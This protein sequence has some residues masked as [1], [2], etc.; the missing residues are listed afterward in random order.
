[1]QKNRD[2]STSLQSKL[3]TLRMDYNQVRG[4]PFA[5]F[6]CPI[7]FRDEDVPLCK[8][9]IVNQAFP[10]S[11]SNWTVQRKDVDNFYGSVFEADFLAFRYSKNRS[12]ENALTDRMLQKQLNP[13][14]LLDDKQLDYFFSGGDIPEH[15]TRLNIEHEG[16]VVQF[17]LK[18][19]PESVL[20][21]T[22]QKWE[23]SISDSLPIWC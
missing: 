15:F 18:L 23:V 8:A 21:A 5:Y 17:G 2:M 4:H 12:V 13:Q 6:Y 9:H 3:E 1:M 11:A 14:I 16:Q 7:L 10:N 20:A 22:N 19:P